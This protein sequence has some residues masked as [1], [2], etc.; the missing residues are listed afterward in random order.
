M[1]VRSFREHLKNGLR[2]DSKMGRDLPYCVQ[3][4]GVRPTPYGARDYLQIP[5]PGSFAASYSYPFPQIQVGNSINLIGG[6]DSLKTVDIKSTSWAAN[7]PTF[8]SKSQQGGTPTLP[9]GGGVWHFM[10]FYTT[11]MAF[12]GISTVTAS[13]WAATPLLNVFGQVLGD[14][15]FLT[16]TGWTVGANWAISGGYAAHTAGSTATLSSSY[17]NLN[18]KIAQY[19]NYKVEVKTST[20][21]AGSFTVKVGAGTS[22]AFVLPTD[23]GTATKTVASGT[24]TPGSNTNDFIVITPSNDFDGRILGISVIPLKGVTI[25]TGAAY[26][27]SQPFL[28]GFNPSDMF[29]CADWPTFLSAYASNIPTEIAALNIA[30]GADMNWVWWGTVGGGDLMWLFDMAIMKYGSE[31]VTTQGYQDDLLTSSVLVDYDNYAIFELMKRN[32]FGMRPMPWQGKVVGM[33]QLGRHMMVYG[34]MSN[35][36]PVT[37]VETNIVQ[38]KQQPGGIAGLAPNANF[39][40]MDF[41]RQLPQHV[42][43]V[44][45]GGFAGDEETH[46]IYDELDNLWLIDANLQAKRLNYSSFVSGFGSDIS[47]TFDNHEKEFYITDGSDTLMLNDNG[48]SKSPWHPTSVFISQGARYG[49]IRNDSTVAIATIETEMV[50]SQGQVQWGRI[51]GKNV[52]SSGWS[53]AINWRVNSSQTWTSTGAVA[54]DARGICYFNL[55]TLNL[56]YTVTIT[57]TR[58][59][60][61]VDD[62]EI[63]EQDGDH[64]NLRNLFDASTPGAATE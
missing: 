19:T 37:T 11:W 41:V 48:L 56:D 44:G 46:L 40:G 33:K 27:E 52:S 63:M 8:V 26:N 25:Q 58:G 17:A 6:A 47:I 64:Y 34:A 53:M 1:P 30:G 20:W 18:I 39:Y 3:Y 51:V 49:I 55:P 13:G 21:T 23:L 10:D 38:Y 22:A 50:T 2:P 31:T 43:V 12:N 4:Q 60:I 28:A 54:P 45:R 32:E 7:I 36:E 59:L 42:G 16:G 29:N 9:V 62:I 15:L 61:S 5:D 35:Q 14:P 57:G 24:F